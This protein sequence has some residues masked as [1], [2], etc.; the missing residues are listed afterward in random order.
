M[1]VQVRIIKS[2]YTDVPTESLQAILC[3]HAHDRL[4]VRISI[5]QLYDIMEVLVQRREEEDPNAFRSNEEALADFRQ[6]YMPKEPK[7]L[8]YDYAG[9]FDHALL[10][11]S[12]VLPASCYAVDAIKKNGK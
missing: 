1:K 11:L 8:H 9:G 7:R 2:P 12:D 5:R 4:L 3:N 6:H 10:E